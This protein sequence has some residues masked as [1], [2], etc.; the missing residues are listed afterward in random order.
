MKILKIVNEKDFGIRSY[1]A[2]NLAVSLKKAGHEAV[3]MCPEDSALYAD[4]EKYKIERLN[5]G[6]LE[7]MGLAKFPRAD[8]VD[9]YSHFQTLPLMIK[10]FSDDKIPVFYRQMDFFRENDVKKIRELEKYAFR[11]LPSCQSIFDE[12]VFSG[13]NIARLFIAPP[14]LNITRWESAKLIKPAMFLKRPFKVG[15]AYRVINNAELELFLKIAKAVMDV[16]PDTNFVLVGPKYEKIR[17]R[18]REMGISHKIDMLDWRTDMPEV[19]AMIHIFLKTNLEPGVSRSL[20]EAMTSGV[21]CV[22]PRVKGL[23]DFIEHDRSGLVVEPGSV[24]EFADAVLTLIRNAPMCQAL[25]A[26]SYNYVND[27]MSLK[28]VTNLVS[29]L[30]EEGIIGMGGNQK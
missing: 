16:I 5:L 27:N 14:V 3:I 7:K 12:L 4:A 10:K 11:I 25:Y 19:M 22:I 30:Y 2:L 28:V 23:E 8:V 6:L 21:A 24:D 1:N 26:V 18:A 15:M 9:V 13:V 29:F 20:M 17:E